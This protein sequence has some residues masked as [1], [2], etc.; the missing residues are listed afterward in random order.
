MA[1]VFLWV[2]NITGESIDAASGASP[3]FGDIELQDWKLSILNNAPQRMTD[4]DKDNDKDKGKDKDNDKVTLHT[5]V[6]DLVVT[7]WIDRATKPLLQYCAEAT[8]IERA[9]LTLRKLA[10]DH[11][12]EYFVVDFTNLKVVSVDWLTGDDRKEQ[13]TFKFE[14]FKLRYKM[15]D[16]TG[17]GPQ[18]S[19][20]FGWNQKD[21]EELH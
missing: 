18:G 5:K 20:A 16:N 19:V 14:T 4:K 10:G 8:T 6:S 13:I 1:E 12:Y 9:I 21:H 3:H 11:K 17:D 7:K 15:Q 2:D